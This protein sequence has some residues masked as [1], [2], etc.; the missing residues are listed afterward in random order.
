MYQGGLPGGVET[1]AF[2][3]QSELVGGEPFQ[4]GNGRAFVPHLSIGEELP[5]RAGA[6]TLGGEPSRDGGMGGVVGVHFPWHNG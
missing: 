2:E 1:R 4:S 3:L 6:V 5:G